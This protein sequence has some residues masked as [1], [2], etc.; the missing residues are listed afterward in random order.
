MLNILSRRK[1][2][3]VFGD[4]TFERSFYFVGSGYW[5]GET[6]FSPLQR[7]VKVGIRAERCGIVDGHREFYRELERRYH[8][9]SEPIKDVLLEV[10]LRYFGPDFFGKMVPDLRW[11]DFELDL[12]SLPTARGREKAWNLSYRFIPHASFY[13][14][15]FE[16]WEPVFGE[17]DD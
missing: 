17:L 14:V 2:D 8:E 10:P 6:Y 13:S 4:L 1:H 7:K 11:E 16:G 12:I 5:R 9:L 15:T 3:I